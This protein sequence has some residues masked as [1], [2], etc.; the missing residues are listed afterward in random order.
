MSDNLLKLIPVEP[1]FVPSEEAQAKAKDL[2]A[3]FLPAS[4]TVKVHVEDQIR[5]VDPGANFETILCPHC[6]SVVSDEWW[7][8]AMDKAYETGFVDLLAKMPCCGTKQSL[9]DLQ[10]HWPAGFSRF[11]LEAL[12]PGKDLTDAELA[13]LQTAVGAKLRKIWVHR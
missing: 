5:F 7:Q 10:Y 4:T 12:N 9:N 11:V 3:R 13:A 2:L 6:L 1:S 8:E